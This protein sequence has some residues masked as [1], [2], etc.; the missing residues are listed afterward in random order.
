MIHAIEFI[1]Y[2]K[3]SDQNNTV[4][5]SCC[6]KNFIIQIKE[7]INLFN[8]NFILLFSLEKIDFV[9]SMFNRMPLKLIRLY[10]SKN[11]VKKILN[12]KNINLLVLGNYSNFISQYCTQQIKSEIHVL[13]DGIGSLTFS[14]K[15]RIN[16]I[17]NQIPIFNFNYKKTALWIVKLIMN[18][19]NYV[20]PEK[21]TFFS[22]YN[23]DVLGKDKH[24]L[25]DYSFLKSLYQKQKIDSEKVFF[26]GSPLSEVGFINLNRE[27]DLIIN[28]SRQLKSS[29]LFYIPH[30]KDSKK[31]I[32]LIRKHLEIL[33]FNLPIEFALTKI[34]ALPHTIT[35]FSTS[36]LPSLK[37][38]LR[39]EVSF[40]AVAIPKK[41]YFDLTTANRISEVYNSFSSKF[42]IKIIK[43]DSDE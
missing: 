27:T 7:I 2:F 36:A 14:A 28:Y 34:E 24:I 37:K 4:V 21:I 38:I 32:D 1:Y 8:L 18:F 41:Y 3:L 35:G 17:N 16:E 22:S 30:R 33:Q 20:I 5:I 42:K 15:N 23:F 39:K 12:K 29:K 43:L 9:S 40:C 10:V 11:R 25:N 6:T 13:D 26:I 19:N 31:K